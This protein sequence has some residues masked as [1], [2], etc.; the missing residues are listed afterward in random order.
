LP[1]VSG[2]VSGLWNPLELSALELALV[3]PELLELLDPQAETTRTSAH[4]IALLNA[5]G[6]I[7]LIES[8]LLTSLMIA[9]LG[10]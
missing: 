3:P 4:M 6:L 8:C 5:T 2:C 10:R 7:E 9:R 1:P